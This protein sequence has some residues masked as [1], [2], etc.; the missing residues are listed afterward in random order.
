MNQL[1]EK[2]N[3]RYIGTLAACI[4]A[5]LL[6]GAVLMVLTGFNPFEAYGAMIEGALG[7]PRFIGNTLERA[8]LLCLLGL[9][10]AIGAKGGLF[11]VGGEGQLFFGALTS[12]MIG[13]WCSNL[14]TI[15]VV[16]LS[17]IGAVVVGGFYAWIPALLKVK[18]GVSE[19]ITTIMLNTVAIKV[20]TY[21]VNGPWNAPSAAIAKGTE[22]LPDTLRFTKLI[23]ASNLTTGF[24]G[25]AVVAFFIWYVMKMTSTGLQIKVTGE[26]ERFARFAGLPSSKLMIGSMV[27]SGAICGFVGMFLVYGSQGHMTEA[28]SN[29]FY[30]DGMLVAMIMNYN[31]VG[32]IIMSFFFAIMSVGAAYMDMMVGVSTQ[33]YDIIFSIIIFLMAAEKGINTWLE[34]KKLQKKARKELK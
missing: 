22:Y 4:I 10:T 14:P 31:P 20:C 12:T 32:I 34:H 7:S 13:L 23:Q 25:G 29:E 26:N 30:F 9:A 21:L 11:N 19:V 2:I 28:V 5:A 1:K 17:F 8:M 15:V 24:I 6:I 18:L 27:A 16:V 3:V 33:I